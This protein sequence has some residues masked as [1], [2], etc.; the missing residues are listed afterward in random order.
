MK[1]TLTMKL[2]TA[3]TATK[4]MTKSATKT[5]ATTMTS[6]TTTTSTT[7]TPNK[8]YL[9][10]YSIFKCCNCFLNNKN[11]LPRVVKYTS[12]KSNNAW[13]SNQIKSSTRRMIQLCTL[14]SVNDKLVSFST[15]Y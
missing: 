4:N 10:S 1:S 12:L 11:F 15:A 7:K 14:F 13:V 3:T 2:A 5:S 9:Y 8:C 6:T